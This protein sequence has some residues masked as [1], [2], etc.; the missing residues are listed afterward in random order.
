MNLDDDGTPGMEGGLVIPSGPAAMAPTS[1]GMIFLYEIGADD[2][3]AYRQAR[4]RTPLQRIR[5]LL[6]RIASKSSSEAG[7]KPPTLGASDVAALTTAEIESLFEIFLGSPM[8]QWYA[9]KAREANHAVVRGRGESAVAYFDRLIE[10]YALF[11]HA[12]ASEAHTVD[13]AESVAAA[14]LAPGGADPLSVASG[15]PPAESIPK[16]GQSLQASLG[17]IQRSLLWTAGAMMLAVAALSVGGAWLG[18]Q[19]H[20][21]DREND[22]KN[23]AW[24]QQMKMLAENNS[25]ME[26][27]FTEM[28]TENARLK[29]RLEMLESRRAG[30]APKPAAQPPVRNTPRS[31]AKST[32]PPAKK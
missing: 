19:L 16:L 5:G 8:N 9:M 3:S 13:G 32:R 21:R 1:L 23:E 12:G 28:A 25:A 7:E 29:A 17:S 15:E 30:N 22:R 14:G 27:G 18:Y 11:R 6:E 2:L 31:P 26:R 24:Q 10:W 20:A 4:G